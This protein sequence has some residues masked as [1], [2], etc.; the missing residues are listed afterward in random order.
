MLLAVVIG[1]SALSGC[2]HGT[3]T[4][5]AKPTGTPLTTPTRSSQPVTVHGV[6]RAGAL[7]GC[8]VV[9]ADDGRHYVLLDTTDP[10]LNVPSG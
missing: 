10:P 8:Y 7:P 2:N 3:A 4:V 9:Q 6:I 5:P 1:V